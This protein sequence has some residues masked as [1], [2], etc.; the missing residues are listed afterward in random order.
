MSDD[1]KMEFGLDMCAKAT[2]K[3]GKEIS[4][5]GI[6]LNDNKV[7]QDI[8]PESTYTY[9][10]M[11]VRN[12]TDHHKMKAKTQKQYK[13]RI[14]L[15]PKS[16]FTARNKIAAINTLAVPVVSYSYGGIN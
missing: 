13:R 8:E 15:V 2:F 7:K 6:Q 9:L 16:E 1:I 11:E 3:R 4:A 5:E 10:G 12:G 14:R